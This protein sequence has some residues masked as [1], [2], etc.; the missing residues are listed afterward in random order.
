MLRGNARADSTGNIPGLVEHPTLRRLARALEE[1]PGG[2]APDDGA[3]RR[4]AVAVV[5]RH[6]GDDV[7]ELLLIKRSERVGDPWSGHVA[8][9]GGRHEPGD[10]TLQDTAV[11]ETLEETGIDIARDGVVL[12]MLDELRPR[13]PVLPPIIVTPFVAVVP[14]G[15]AIVASDEVADAFWVPLASLADPSIAVE[16]EVTSRG[17]TW[18]VPTYQL[19]VHVVWGMTERILRNLLSL[20]EPRSVL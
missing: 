17:T 15:V 13:T 2:L 20:I 1:R 8:L 6:I 10:A 16:S 3:P 9:P 5:F 18:R 12:G 19:G 4:A 11:R 14:A 7:L